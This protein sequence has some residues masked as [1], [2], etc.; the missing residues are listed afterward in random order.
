MALLPKNAVSRCFGKLTRLR[1]PLLSAWLRDA[2]V[3]YYHIDMEDAELPQSSYATLGSLFIRKLKPGARPIAEGAEVVSPVDGLLSQTGMLD[4]GSM[5]MIQAKGKTYTLASLL[6]DE[7][8]ARQFA[9]GSWATIYLAPYNYH[10]IHS[11]VAGE[12]VSAHYCPGNLWPVNTGSVARIEGLF[13]VNERLVSRLRVR[14]DGEILVVKVGATNVGRIAVTYTEDLLTNDACSP[15]RR[16]ARTDW[17]PQTQVAFARGAELGRFEMGST[18][19]LVCNKALRD[20]NPQLFQGLQGQAV[21]M[22]QAL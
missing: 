8:L 1:L 21:R 9:G 15:D 12:L 5:E 6:R 22:G 3:S 10:R 11:P 18:V 17:F 2:F 4:Y 20:R 19:I 7:S 16:V 14:E 13:A